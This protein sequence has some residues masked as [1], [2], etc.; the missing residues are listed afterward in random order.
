MYI[1]GLDVAIPVEEYPNYGKGPLY[2]G[3]GIVIVQIS[4]FTCFGA[5]Q[6]SNYSGRP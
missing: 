4:R 5:Y 1:A 3:L 2:P 6:G